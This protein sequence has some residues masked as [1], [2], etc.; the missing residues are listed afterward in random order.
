MHNIF[1]IIVI[2]HMKLSTEQRK[3][4]AFVPELHE[5]YFTAQ[6]KIL[7]PLRNDSSR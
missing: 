1:S 7:L 4:N 2:Y 6:L 3:Q 5:I